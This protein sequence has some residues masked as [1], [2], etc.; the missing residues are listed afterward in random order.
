MLRFDK[1]SSR[2]N[3]RSV[4]III[5]DDCVLM[6][7]EG[8]DDFWSLPGGRVEFF[9]SSEETLP[10]EIEEELG[11]NGKVQRLVFFVEN[12]FE[13][14]GTKYHELSTYYTFQLINNISVR[15]NKNFIGIEDGSEMVFRWVPLPEIKSFNLKPH[16]LKKKL[17]N[18]PVHIEHIVVNEFTP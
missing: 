12:F 9:E 13:F 16:F 3:I 14:K 7:K 15:P 11:F 1:G 10:R 17:N 2:L 8:D 6:H 5:I 18:L 4:A